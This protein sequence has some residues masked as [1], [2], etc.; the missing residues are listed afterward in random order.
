MI[1]NKLLYI[2]VFFLKKNMFKNKFLFYKIWENNFKNCFWKYLVF[3]KS[4]FDY[5]CEI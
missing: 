3:F 4:P 2:K 5:Y 1:K